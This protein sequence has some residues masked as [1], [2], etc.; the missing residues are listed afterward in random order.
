MKRMITLL[1][2]LALLATSCKNAPESKPTLS[3]PGLFEYVEAARQTEL[4]EGD[5]FEAFKKKVRGSFDQRPGVAERFLTLDD[6]LHFALLAVYAKLKSKALAPGVL[7]QMINHRTVNEKDVE[8]PGIGPAFA[9]LENDVMGFAKTHG[10]HFDTVDHVAH[11][12]SLRGAKEAQERVG[13][14][15]CVKR[16]ARIRN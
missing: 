16:F 2:L 12:V 11:A 6:D 5:D 14:L 10:L 8:V 1:S 7:A 3:E 15:V 9:A 13:V 4:V